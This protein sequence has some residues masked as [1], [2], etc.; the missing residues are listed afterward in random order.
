MRNENDDGMGEKTWKKMVQNKKESGQRK[1]EGEKV[2]FSKPPVTYC[3]CPSQI[4]KEKGGIRRWW[5]QCRAL[6]TSLRDLSTNG[7]YKYELCCLNHDLKG[8]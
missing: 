2:K 7:C 1:V 8:K 4:E 5:E 3:N 6:R